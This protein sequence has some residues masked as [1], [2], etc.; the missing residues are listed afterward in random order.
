MELKEFLEFE[1]ILKEIILTDIELKRIVKKI[2]RIIRLNYNSKQIGWLRAF[3]INTDA[4]FI[5]DQEYLH[6]NVDTNKLLL[7]SYFICGNMEY[8][9][10]EL[11]I[12]GNDFDVT[13]NVLMSYR[14]PYINSLN[15]F[16]PKEKQINEN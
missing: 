3:N 14:K 13:Q 12:C 1:L 16:L 7:G 11:R 15:F 6:M 10:W 5:N 4:A 2:K 9:N 8:T